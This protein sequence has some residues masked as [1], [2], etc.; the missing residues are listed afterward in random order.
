MFNDVRNKA[1]KRDFVLLH[2]CTSSSHHSWMTL[3]SL[4][5]PEERIPPQHRAYHRKG[6]LG[7]PFLITKVIL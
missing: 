1:K 5:Y 4:S 7:P 2:A 3:P 6:L